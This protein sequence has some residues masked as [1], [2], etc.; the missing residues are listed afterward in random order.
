MSARRGCVGEAMFSIFV[1]AIGE[2]CSLPGSVWL[3]C[4]TDME[5]IWL[6]LDARLVSVESVG[7][8][9]SNRQCAKWRH[10]KA[11]ALGSTDVRRRGVQ[12]VVFEWEEEGEEEGRD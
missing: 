4:E 7:R 11:W 10:K 9:A 2:R 5:G 1:V 3:S 8:I 12:R 6:E